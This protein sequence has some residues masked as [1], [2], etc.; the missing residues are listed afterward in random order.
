M[1]N[2]TAPS[3]A[4]PMLGELLA[5]AGYAAHHV[6]KWHLDAAGYAGA[7]RAD[8]GFAND[9]WYDLSRF[10]DEVGRD[11]ANRFGGWLRGLA[12][13]RLC[14]AHRVVDR[15]IEVLRARDPDAPLFLAVELD[16]PHSPY[17]CPPPWSTAC[18]Q[19]PPATASRSPNSPS[20]G[21]SATPRSPSPWSASAAAR[22]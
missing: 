7:G 3:R 9:T 1:C 12:D 21:C 17:I 11:G 18:G 16:E 6:G 5:E 8:G 2:D 10:Y 15:A 13:A 22:N 14:F 19:S 20:P 4:V